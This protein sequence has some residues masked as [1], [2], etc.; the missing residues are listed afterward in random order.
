MQSHLVQEQIT[1]FWFAPGGP[2][3]PGSPWGAPAGG[4]QSQQLKKKSAASS[5][6]FSNGKSVVAAWN[7]GLEEGS[8]ALPGAAGP[9]LFT[10][11]GVK[12]GTA[13]S[14]SW[15]GFGLVSI[16]TGVTF[17]AACTATSSSSSSTDAEM[18]T[19]GLRMAAVGRSGRNHRV[20]YTHCLF[21]C[22]FH[23]LQYTF[24]FFDPNHHPLLFHDEKR[25]PLPPQPNCSQDIRTMAAPSPGDMCLIGNITKSLF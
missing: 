17:G 23:P 21:S 7:A 11:S 2:G 16:T 13:A 15:S 24:C 8:W 14:G 6:S 9:E 25:R 12:D 20:S 18:A 5:V 10:A 22:T 4:Q 3:S 19:G 1:L